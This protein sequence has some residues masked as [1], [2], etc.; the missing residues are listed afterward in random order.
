MALFLATTVVGTQGWKQT[1]S[2]T[3]SL[4]LPKNVHGTNDPPSETEKDLHAIMINL[5]S[6]VVSSVECVSRDNNLL[7]LSLSKLVFKA[8][9]YLAICLVLFWIY[10]DNL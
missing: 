6:F 5:S 3:D 8:D 7:A 10:N 4:T 9:V 1:L 2:L